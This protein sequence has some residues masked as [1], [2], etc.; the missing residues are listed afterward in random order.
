MAQI[1]LLGGGFALV[2][3]AD[4]AR[5]SGR[6]W[7]LQRDASTGDARAVVSGSRG[8]V[9]LM[10]RLLMQSKD[11][12]IVDH[13]NRDPTDN[14]RAN[15]RPCSVAENCR[16]RGVGRNNQCGLKGVY[17]DR[18]NRSVKVWRAQIR[19]DGRKVCLGRFESAEAAGLAYDAAAER[20]HGQFAV[21][22]ADLRAA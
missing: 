20:L 10:H 16:N 5:V 22:N 1:P 21:T 11:G 4:L 17:R 7:R 2:D 18:S 13:V 15:L 19:V 9:T 14:R 3:D 6:V 8:K 12:E